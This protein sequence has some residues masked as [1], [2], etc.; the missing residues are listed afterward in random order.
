MSVNHINDISDLPRHFVRELRAFFEDYKK[1]EE[2]E[3]VIE[4]FLG[5]EEAMKIIE[6][7]FVDYD[8]LMA[9]EK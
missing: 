3:V 4:D 6:Q 7:S 5:K 2:K 1:L 8:K 9:E